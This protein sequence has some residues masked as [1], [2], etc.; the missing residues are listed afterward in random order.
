MIVFPTIV[1][2]T[3]S[4]TTASTPAMVLVAANVP[5][6]THRNESALLG[7]VVE[8]KTKTVSDPFRLTR[9]PRRSA[10]TAPDS[11]LILAEGTMVHAPVVPTSYRIAAI[12][13]PDPIDGNTS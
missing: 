9:A 13:N 4:T 1:P 7:P 11:P 6:V 8:D 3:P 12:V 5:A 2:S 10:A